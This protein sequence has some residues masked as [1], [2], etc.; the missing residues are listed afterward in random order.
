MC[1]I[2]SLV[3]SMY[4]VLIKRVN[5]YENFYALRFIRWKFHELLVNRNLEI[6]QGASNLLHPQFSID[7]Y[8]WRVGC[9]TLR[10]CIISGFDNEMYNI[11]D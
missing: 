2:E 9:K 11:V 8:N 5:V 4:F 10:I 6:V 3:L 7:N 1:I